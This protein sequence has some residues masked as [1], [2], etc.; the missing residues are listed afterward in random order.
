LL[1]TGWYGNTSL[2][3][4]LK[5]Y[6]VK[7]GC[8]PRLRKNKLGLNKTVRIAKNDEPKEVLQSL[9]AAYSI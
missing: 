9:E 1:K 7:E 3:Y 6:F 5:E 8:K 2:G 4:A